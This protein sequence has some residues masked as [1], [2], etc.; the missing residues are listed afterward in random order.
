MNGI[1]SWLVG[2][3]CV[4]YI[5]KHVV[6]WLASASQLGREYARAEADV[7]RADRENKEQQRQMNEQMKDPAY[8]RAVEAAEQERRRQTG[9]QQ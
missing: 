8:R 2:I 3:A 5:G 7:E 9:E 6:R 1:V 4:I